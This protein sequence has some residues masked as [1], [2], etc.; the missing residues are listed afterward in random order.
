MNDN[1]LETKT[2]DSY[3]EHTHS[4][5]IIKKGDK[6]LN[7]FDE[8]WGTYLFPN[9]KGNDIEK[10]KKMYNTDNVEFLFDKIHNKYSV[11]NK[12]LRTYH[13]YFYKVNADVDGEYFTLDELLNKDGVRESNG[14]IIEF[15]KES[16]I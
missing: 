8:R 3:K 9:I 14:D 6:Y 11:P 5:I 13:H 4:I 15:I 7:Y 1:K 10:I 12:E 16:L 2:V